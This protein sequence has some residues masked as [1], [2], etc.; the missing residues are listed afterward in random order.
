[1]GRRIILVVAALHAKGLVHMDLKPDNLMLFGNKWK[2]IDVEGCVCAGTCARL[3]DNVIYNSPCYCAPEMARFLTQENKGAIAILPSLDVWSVG[4]VTCELAHLEAVL[5]PRYAKL[6]KKALSP[7]HASRIFL[8]WLGGTD[9]VDFLPQDVADFDLGL[10]DLVVDWLL[11]LDGTKRK[12]LAQCL[13]SPYL[14]AAGAP[15]TPL[16][17]VANVNASLRC[18]PFSL[19]SYLLPACIGQCWLLSFSH[20]WC[21][22]SRRR[23]PSAALMSWQ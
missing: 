17:D 11:V 7:R 10:R 13:S 12:S 1:M 16:S 8:S 18:S 14:A 3:E 6:S 2:L 19:F 23:A 21:I 5:Q 4:M 22:F 20:A 9:R 15:E